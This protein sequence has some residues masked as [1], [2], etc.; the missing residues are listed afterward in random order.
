MLIN[1]RQDGVRRG[2]V[3]SHWKGLPASR[4]WDCWRQDEVG[5]EGSTVLFSPTG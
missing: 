3:C 4:G 5:G 1:T 2:L